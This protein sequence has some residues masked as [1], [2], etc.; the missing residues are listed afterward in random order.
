MH[1]KLILIAFK[2]GEKERIRSGD[3]SPAPT[4][5][6]KTISDYLSNDFGMGLTE[7]RLMQFY[8]DANH[9]QRSNEDI[10]ISK[11]KVVEGL[12]N[13]V[14]YKNYEEFLKSIAT[15]GQRLFYFLK[16]NKHT[17][18]ICF[19]TIA[20]TIVVTL[21]GGQRWMTWDGVEYVE[22]SFDKEKFEKGELKMY[23]SDHVRN[24]KKIQRPSCKTRYFN[25]KG[26]AITWYYKVKKGNL[27]VYTAPGLH[28]TNGKTLKPITVY[29]IQ[30]HICH[31][32]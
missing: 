3:N 17:L 20:I 15:P 5:I 18:I 7:R 30:E 31:D 29:M 25:D 8:N 19:F 1:K 11:I 14:G 32:Y 13:Y 12:C 10:N 26:E 16:K 27:E 2:K 4:N 6:A 21:T 9:L 28:P 23:N 24:F 22:V